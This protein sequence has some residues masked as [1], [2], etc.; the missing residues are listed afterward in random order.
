[1][2]ITKVPFAQ[3]IGLTKAE[4]G[5]LQLQHNKSVMNHVQTIAAAAQYSLAELACGNYLQQLFPELIGQ[6]LPVLR[7]SRL[8]YKKPAASTISAHV[9]TKEKALARFNQQFEKKGRAL[10]TIDVEVKDVDGVVTSKGNFVWYV[11]KP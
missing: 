8:K 11:Q 2:E 1:M 9:S 5:T 4:D 10:I 7:D 6:V 3:T